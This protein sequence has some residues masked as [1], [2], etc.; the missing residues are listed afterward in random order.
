MRHAIVH[1]V[2]PA[3]STS[4]IGR[5][6]AISDQRE[7]VRR[8]RDAYVG[9]PAYP[10]GQAFSQ[11]SRSEGVRDIKAR[12]TTCGEG[13]VHF[14]TY[15]TTQTRPLPERA[16][17]ADWPRL[18]SR[19]P[20]TCTSA[21]NVRTTQIR[22]S[23]KQILKPA[24]D[25]GQLNGGRLETGR[26]LPVGSSWDELE[27]TGSRGRATFPS[28]TCVTAHVNR[29]A[30]SSSVVGPRVPPAY[31]SAPGSCS[32]VAQARRGRTR[33]MTYTATAISSRCYAGGNG[34]LSCDIRS[35]TRPWCEPL[36]FKLPASSAYSDNGGDGRAAV[37]LPSDTC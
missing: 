33:A 10:V 36:P 24:G 35:S 23:S 1:A 15:N 34:L 14:D 25:F 28:E 8:A 37:P 20:A 17:G 4:S 32:D 12:V 11:Q 26:P 31:D 7:A 22:A 19:R 27:T 2:R 18:F 6:E 9:D 3:S 16:R 13:R 30:T 5:R 29:P 21:G